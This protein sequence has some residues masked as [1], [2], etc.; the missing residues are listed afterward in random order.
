MWKCGIDGP[1]GAGTAPKTQQ[2]NNNE[3]QSTCEQESGCPSKIY[4]DR[5]DLMMLNVVALSQMLQQ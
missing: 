2:I 4:I 3:T 1:T 5:T